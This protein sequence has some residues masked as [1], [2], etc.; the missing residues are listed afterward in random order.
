MTT[1]LSIRRIAAWLLAGLLAASVAGCARFRHRPPSPEGAPA[2]GAPAAEEAPAEGAPAQPPA[3]AS[4]DAD[5][6]AAA[7]EAAESGPEGDAEAEKAPG[8]GRR[9]NGNG[10]VCVDEQQVRAMQDQALHQQDGGR[11]HGMLRHTNGV[12]RWLDRTHDTWYR[13][14]DNAVRSVDTRWLGEEMEYEPELSSFRLSALGRIGGTD[15]QKDTDVKVRFRGDLALPGLENKLHLI[16]ENADDGALPGADPMTRDE[17]TQLGLRAVWDT[18]L[19]N[20]AQ[21]DAGLKW[22]NSNPV[23]FLE[24]QWKWQRD[25]AG[26]RLRLNPRGLYFSDEGFGQVTTLSWTRDLGERTCLQIRLAERSS[27]ARDGVNF[28][29]TFRFAWRRSGRGRGWVAQASVFPSLVSS[30]WLWEDTLVS[31]TWRDAF[32]RRWI[33]CT[34]TPQVQFPR[35]DSYEAR[36]SLRIGFEVLFGGRV[37][38]LM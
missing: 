13:R 23:A 12:T 3:E 8:N 17:D 37:G 1:A 11:D 10:T 38:D 33:Y 22:R 7:E 25:A 18:L 15:S 34:V 26:G 5:A 2:E 6:P 4:A 21:A 9:R 35:E 16:L 20:R 28:E 29:Q 19:G 24:L 14:M 27:E 36:F 32:Y 31:L 30:D